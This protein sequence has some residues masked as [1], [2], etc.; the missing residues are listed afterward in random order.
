MKVGGFEHG[1]IRRNFLTGLFLTGAAALFPA[2][3]A[4]AYDVVKSDGEW[5]SLLAPAAYD[6]LRHA[7]T[8]YPFTSPLDKNFA[9]GIYSCAGCDLPNFSSDTKYD[10]GSGWPS[11]WKPLNNAILTASD[12]S[13]MMNRT[14][15]HCRRCGGHLGHV[16]DDGPRP[17][18]L[19]YCMNGVALKFTKAT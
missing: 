12:N 7:G 1:L 5:K 17:T 9:R 16:F 13:D 14:E 8:E 4:F 6:V 15:V 3:D 19:R 11:F 10:S 2:R 18:G